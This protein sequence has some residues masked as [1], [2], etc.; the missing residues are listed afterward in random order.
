MKRT[1]QLVTFLALASATG[2]CSKKEAKASLPDPKAES[3]PAAVSSALKVASAS[4]EQ[5][6]EVRRLTATGSTR[7]I[8]EADVAA[9]IGGKLRQVKVDEGDRVKKNQ[10]LFYSDGGTSGL[11]IREA[12]VG[13]SSAEN[14]YRL[15]KTDF[16]RKERLLKSGSISQAAFDQAKTQ[17]NDAKLAIKRAKVGL[18]QAQ[19]I[20]GDSYVASPISGVVAQRMKEPGEWVG[21]G[22]TVLVIQNISSLEVRAR[23]PESALARVKIGDRAVVRFR[24]VNI[25]RDTTVKRLSP[26]VDPMTRTVEVVSIVDNKDESLK[27]GMLVQVEFP[28]AVM[29]E[30][31]AAAPAPSAATAKAN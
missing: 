8:D 30:A 7:A 9:V 4:P 26:S 16:E 1:M 22:G 31:T 15:A 25:T 24:S 20:A 13:V 3:A 2:A 29:T 27:A 12:K 5:V 23:L 10:L 14:A 6:D 11:R 17:F 18:K 28:D 19:S 21:A